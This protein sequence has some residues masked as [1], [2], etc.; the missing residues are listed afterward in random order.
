MNYKEAADTYLHPIA[1][2]TGFRSINFPWSV[3]YILKY[4]LIV[5]TAILKEM[6]RMGK[7]IPKE[8]YQT[9][10]F[11]MEEAEKVDCPCASPNNCIWMKSVNKL[12]LAIGGPLV[13]NIAGDVVYSYE[14]WESLKNSTKSRI[15]A[16]KNSNKVYT[17]KNGHIILPLDVNTKVISVSGLFEDPYEAQSASCNADANSKCNPLSAEFTADS[18]LMNNILMRT[19]QTLPNIR[20]GAAI[21]IINNDT[22]TS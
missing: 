11:K 2:K 6:Q 20:N 13:T 3:Q 4:M 14:S 7:E 8:N 18:D 12:P 10:C 16:I 15:P 22:P 19:W 21:D 1:D 9:F 5:R 17:I